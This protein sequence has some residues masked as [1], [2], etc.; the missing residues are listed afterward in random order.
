MAA[1]LV[2]RQLRNFNF[3]SPKETGKIDKPAKGNLL[4]NTRAE[5]PER[6]IWGWFRAMAGITVAPVWMCLLL[7]GALTVAG[8]TR[9]F[10]APATADPLLPLAPGPSSA[11]LSQPPV[12]P[13]SAEL[14]DAPSVASSSSSE[15][16]I[17][18]SAASLTHAASTGF[19]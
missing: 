3:A 16:E 1:I 19:L 2:Q 11:A 10:S 14:P 7:A 18:N 12:R 4:L 15:K 13:R 8:Q 6:L 5:F 9:N 17:G